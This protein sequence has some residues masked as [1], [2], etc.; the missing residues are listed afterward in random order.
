MSDE[1]LNKTKSYNRSSGIQGIGDTVELMKEYDMNNLADTIGEGEKAEFKNV[2][3]RKS[4]KN[5]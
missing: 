2:S 5:S 4:S 3:V 1:M